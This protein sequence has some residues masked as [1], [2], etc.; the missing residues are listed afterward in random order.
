LEYPI[1]RYAILM[2]AIS[3]APN[4]ASTHPAVNGLSV[5]IPVYNEEGAIATTIERCLAVEPELRAAGIERFELIVVDDGS[6]DRSVETIRSYPSVRLIQHGINR[7]YGAALKTGFAAANHELIG[8]LDADAT[9]PPEHLPNLCRAMIDRDA[10][11]VIGSRMTGADSEMPLTRRMGNLFFARLLTFIAREPI[12]DSASGMRVFRREVL[13]V[14]SPLPDGL[15]LTP[16]MSTRAAHE[17]IHVIELPIPYRERV[18]Q[19]HLSITRDGMRFLQ[20]IVWTALAYNPV[21]ILGA[22]GLCGV[23]LALAVTLGLVAMRLQGETALGPIGVFAVFAALVCGVA[24]VSIFSLG[25]SFNY[26]V[27][28]FHRRPIRQGLFRKPLFTTPIERWFLPAGALTFIAGLLLC[29]AS[30]TLSLRGWPIERLWLYLSGSALLVLTGLQ[31]GSWWLVMAVLS[32]L[33]Q[34]QQGREPSRE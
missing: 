12:S 4:R 21:R 7:G 28:L 20:T 5:C 10:D 16:V 11:L 32:E 13:D 15:N 2:P 18:G 6:G 23:A 25:A 9:Y 1:L 31:F 24:G 14:L 27:S 26:L 17:Q 30:F 3:A 33:N 19:S 8:F 29:A 22:V 34:R